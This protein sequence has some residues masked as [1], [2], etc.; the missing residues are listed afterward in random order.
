MR[1]ISAKFHNVFRFG[2]TD[3][4]INFDDVFDSGSIALICGSI[5]GD[6]NISNGAGKSSIGEAIYWALYE[7]LPRL[8]RN[9][10]RKGTAVEEIIRKKDDGTIADCKEAYVELRFEACDGL[11]W[12]LKRG[13]K[14]AKSKKH[15]SILELE[16]ENSEESYRGKK[17]APELRLQQIVGASHES[18]L[19]S[20]F[21]AQKDSGKFISGTDKARRDILMDIRGLQIIDRMLK[22]LRDKLK[23]KCNETCTVLESKIDVLKSRTSGE[24]PDEIRKQKMELAKDIQDAENERKQ[25]NDAIAVL[26]SK[27][28]TSDRDVT[29][30]EIEKFKAELIS[31]ERERESQLADVNENIK[32][33]NLDLQYA[34][35]ELAKID[36]E[37]ESVDRRFKVA[38]E[39]IKKADMD[40]LK[41]AKVKIK[42]AN[43]AIPQLKTLS[44]NSVDLY[45]SANAEIAGLQTNLEILSKDLESSKSMRESPTCPTCGAEW[46]EEE[47]NER[48]S[49]LESDVEILSKKISDKSANRDALREQVESGRKRL[50][51]ERAIAAQESGL[52]AELEKLKSA[53]KESDRCRQDAERIKNRNADMEIKKSTATLRSTELSN[54]KDNRGKSSRSR[55]IAVEDSLKK[56]VEKL[57]VL[58]DEITKIDIDVRGLRTCIETINISTN[59]SSNKIARLDERLN[60]MDRDQKDMDS[61]QKEYDVERAMM[62]RIQYFDKLFSGD[63]KDE[64]AQS[65]IP[66]L[67][68]YANDFLTILRD[69]MR[70]E[71][72]SDDG[73]MAIVVRGGSAPTYDMLSGGEQEAVRLSVDMALSMLSIGGISDLPDMVFLDEIFGSLDTKTRSNVFSLLNRLGKNFSRILV[74][75]HDQLLRD[76]FDTIIRVDK[77][78]GISNISIVKNGE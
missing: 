6:E 49:K 59:Q 5:D 40:K 54:L 31:I 67:N 74:I 48:I 7:K 46:K 8:M 32:Q 27:K 15:T 65:C 23:K 41:A 77:M 78:D 12:R 33:N 38:S 24:S 18:F 43:D 55:L 17:D 62:V 11:V 42:Q 51:K 61:M 28:P 25:K 35:D 73:S 1:I 52:V 26:E 58:D 14:I 75:T 68:L 63:V 47:L 72:R 50:E 53:K 34:C 60:A 57:A 70:V 3:N 4:E 22:H 30:A 9:A 2:E 19:N 13:R 45:G 39:M 56:Q 64:A 37:K 21:F 10:D 76:N 71:V 36:N 69:N 66:L 29:L 20:V 16:C 44:D